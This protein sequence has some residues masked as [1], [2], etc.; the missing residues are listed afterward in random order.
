MSGLVSWVYYTEGAL[1]CLNFF[2]DNF[3]TQLLTAYL[4]LLKHK[5]NIIWMCKN[6]KEKKNIFTRGGH[7]VIVCYISRLQ[8]TT[9]NFLVY[10]ITYWVC[11]LCDHNVSGVVDWTPHHPP[12]CWADGPFSELVLSPLDTDISCD[13]TLTFDRS[14]EYCPLLRCKAAHASSCLTIFCSLLLLLLAPVVWFNCKVICPLVVWFMR[15]HV[16]WCIKPVFNTFSINAF[17]TGWILN[18]NR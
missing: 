9:N 2:W 4:C 17:L 12:V 5:K 10:D 8:P 15:N 1:G 6:G 11:Y 7:K 3:L 16:K 14:S 13:T 18:G